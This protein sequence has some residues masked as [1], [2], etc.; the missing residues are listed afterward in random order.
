MTITVGIDLGT[1]NSSVAY[2]RDGRPM[3]IPIDGSTLLPS[4]VGRS[5]TGDLLVGTPAR[6]QLH[7]FPERTVRSVKRRMGEDVRLSVGDEA[8]TPVEISAIILRRLADAAQQATGEPVERAVITVPAYF[9]D[10]QRTATR[11][12]GVVAGLEVMRILNEPTAASLCYAE[13]DADHRLSLVY[14]LGGGTFDVS[15][16]RSRGDVTEVLASHGDTALGGDDFDDIVLGHLVTAFEKTTGAVVPKDDLRV[17][18]RL[19][20]ASEAARIRLSTVAFT[21]ATEEHLIDVDGAPAHLDVE[22]TRPTLDRLLEPLVS[23]TRDAVQ[24]A[25]RDAGVLARDLDDVILVGGAARTPYVSEMLADLLGRAPRMDINP[26]EAVAL[27]AALHAARL[28]G[29][30]RGRILVDVTPFSFGT[31]YLGELDGRQ[32]SHVYQPIIRRNSPLPARQSHMFYTVVEGQEAVVVRIFQGEEPDAR[33]NVQIGEFRV[34]GLDI[35][36]PAHSPVIFD[37]AL[38]LDGILNV[39]V[40]EKHTGLRKKVRIDDAFGELSS[41]Q[42]EDTRARVREI[43]GAS[44]SESRSVE[45]RPRR[46]PPPDLAAADEADWEAG[47]ALLEKAAKLVPTLDRTD[48]EEVELLT[49]E[50]SGA[51]VE[52][53]MDRVRELAEELADVLFYLET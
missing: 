48:R 38:D 16:V 12:A 44:A 8:L 49:G 39:T 23:R 36:A 26:D 18:A 17:D 21:S 22:L 2:V 5:P 30:D 20:R 41:E 53:Q 40:T 6:N 52:P 14:D 24:I 11:E 42:L 3:L 51:L 43:Y 37:L 13:D 46:A 31:S 28:S 32:S 15:I 29:D 34:D 50:L 25:L 10:A 1:T 7:L 4:V 45:T 47:L 27:G 9:S 19:L 35:D 33:L